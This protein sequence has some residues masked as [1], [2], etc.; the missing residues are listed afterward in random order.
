[1]GAGVYNFNSSQ[2]NYFDRPVQLLASTGLPLGICAHV[3]RMYLRASASAAV[4]LGLTNMNGGISHWGQDYFGVDSEV[5]KLFSENADYWVDIRSINSGGV[6]SGTI[7]A[8]PD[9]V[10]KLHI[11]ADAMYDMAKI[12]S[13]ST[14]TSRSYR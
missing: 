11:G 14:T 7:V 9:G 6:D 12:A 5:Y 3:V 13:G 10:L 2:K 4:S 1:M 8:A